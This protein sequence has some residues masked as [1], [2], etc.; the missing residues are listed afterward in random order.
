MKQLDI[1]GDG[2]KRNTLIARDPRIPIQQPVANTPRTKLWLD[3][4]QPWPRVEAAAP[5]DEN[6]DGLL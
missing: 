4:C 2:R 5:G 6:G 1:G 3:G